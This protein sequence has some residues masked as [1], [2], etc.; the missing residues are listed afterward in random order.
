M[1]NAARL[2]LP[3]LLSCRCP[4]K[5]GTARLALVDGKLKKQQPAP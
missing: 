1:K 2:L 4:T 5:K 3:I